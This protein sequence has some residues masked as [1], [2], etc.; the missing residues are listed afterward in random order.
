MAESILLRKR[1][2]SGSLGRGEARNVKCVHFNVSRMCSFLVC[3][4]ACI[5]ISYL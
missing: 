1:T 2:R 3:S 5:E 4:C